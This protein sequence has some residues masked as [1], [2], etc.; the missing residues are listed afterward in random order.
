MAQFDKFAGTYDELHAESIKASGY[1]P[2]Y[3]DEM[4]IMEV[5]RS[6][7]SAREMKFLNFGCGI[8]KS[9]KYI[10][11]YFPFSMIYSVDVSE[12]SVKAARERN[13]DLEDIRFET[14]DGYNVPFEVEFDVIF[15]ANVLHHVPFE[16]HLPLLRNLCGKLHKNGTLFLFEHNPLNPL[17]VNAVNAC[18]FDKDAR[19]LSPLYTRSILSK[20]GFL[21]K[22]VRFIVFFPRFLSFLLPC[23]KYLRKVPIGAQYYYMAKKT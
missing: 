21:R 8:G 22:Q 4:K 7:K 17:T 5:Y 2:S 9:E 3:F 10:R 13:S 11:R 14:F 6:L 20:S 23:E 1:G 18:E 15:I 19:L 16:R 12:E